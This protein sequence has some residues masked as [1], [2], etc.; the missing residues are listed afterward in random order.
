VLYRS[1]TAGSVGALVVG[2]ACTACD[3]GQTDEPRYAGDDVACD[4]KPR[5]IEL[6]D[7]TLMGFAPS[8]LVE[9]A[10]GP[11]TESLFWTAPPPDF[12]YGPEA[13]MSSVTFE[14]HEVAAR[15]RYVHQEYPGDCAPGCGECS[16]FME[17]PV[18]LG[19]RSDGGALDERFSTTLEAFDSSSAWFAHEVDPNAL[20]GSFEF[21]EGVTDGWKVSLMW[22]ATFSEDGALGT[23]SATFMR[24]ANGRY[25]GR[26]HTLASFPNPIDTE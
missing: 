4:Q 15:G 2:L 8:R 23:L 24:E 26:A 18:V 14:V 7:D 22:G 20:V 25:E 1:L 6:D 9:L 5:E 17:V 16:D 12:P 11:I 10:R 13:G 3:G 19:M 21:G